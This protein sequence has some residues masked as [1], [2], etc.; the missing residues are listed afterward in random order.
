VCKIIVDSA[1]MNYFQVVTKKIFPLYE[2]F[3]EYVIEWKLG[4]SKKRESVLIDDYIPVL[5][6]QIAVSY[7]LF[8][9]S[10][11]DSS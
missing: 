1:A 8:S 2:K 4:E 10:R 7:S 6:K 11:L 5:E 9:T 3:F